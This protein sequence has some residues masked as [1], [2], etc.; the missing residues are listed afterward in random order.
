[1]PE[2]KQDAAS[3]G[4]RGPGALVLVVGPSGAGKD[5][6]IDRA[7]SH[8]ADCRDIV[9]PKRLV[10][11]RPDI[12]REDH[13]EISWPDF[14]ALETAGALT[15]HA[16]GLGYAV[17]ETIRDAVAEGKVVVINVSRTV[18]AAAETAYQNVTVAHVTAPPEILKARLL[19]RDGGEDGARSRLDRAPPVTATRARLVT[20]DNSG[21]I[22]TAADT[23]I[24]AIARQRAACGKP[25]ENGPRP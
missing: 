23:L 2:P 17:P 5:T 24:A 15:W 12:A 10:T 25:A 3:G 13:A 14:Q 6:L 9:F 22:A 11:R 1:M 8:Y 16:H 18:I 21:P 19:A 20:I 4:R 7:R